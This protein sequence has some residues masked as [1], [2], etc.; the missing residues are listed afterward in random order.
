MQEWGID[1]V[2]AAGRADDRFHNVSAGTRDAGDVKLIEG[3]MFI[4]D[5]VAYTQI[6]GKGMHVSGRR[7][8]SALEYQK[9]GEGWRATGRTG[10]AD[11]QVHDSSGGSNPP[12]A[13]GCRLV[14]TDNRLH[15]KIDYKR[16]G[17]RLAKVFQKK[18][19]YPTSLTGS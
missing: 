9:G 4:T 5:V 13:F 10:T 15:V 14:G 16:F 11:S 17:T 1:R 18:R 8:N 2:R 3:E 7:L 6:T 12:L 19:K